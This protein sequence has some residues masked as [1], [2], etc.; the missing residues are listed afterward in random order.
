M[1]FWIGNCVRLEGIGG[2]NYY[3]CVDIFISGCL[4]LLY[5]DDNIYKCEYNF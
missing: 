2:L 5:I 1:K 4:I 3:N